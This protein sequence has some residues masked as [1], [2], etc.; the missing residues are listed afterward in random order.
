MA[1]KFV[2][3]SVKTRQEAVILSTLDHENIVGYIS[4]MPYVGNFAI[5]IELCTVSVADQLKI[6]TRGSAT[7]QLVRFV[8]NITNGYKYLR[9]QGLVHMDIKPGNTMLG[10]DQGRTQDL[11]F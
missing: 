4:S 11:N 8:E 6:H 5:I 3:D 10:Y 2:K 9:T 7:G 1:I